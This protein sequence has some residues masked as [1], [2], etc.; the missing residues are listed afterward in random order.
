VKVHL[1]LKLQ[2]VFFRDLLQFLE[3]DEELGDILG[4]VVG[5]LGLADRILQ[6]EVVLDAKGTVFLQESVLAEN[7]VIVLIPDVHL[8]AFANLAHETIRVDRRSDKHTALLEP[9]SDVFQKSSEHLL[10]LEHV[11]DGKLGANDVEGYMLSD[12]F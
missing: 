4:A 5:E 7:Y 6:V 3:V 12:S 2:P 8:S 10:A 9:V 11:M 1:L